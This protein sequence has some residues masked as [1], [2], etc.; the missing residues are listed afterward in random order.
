MSDTPYVKEKT[1]GEK[2][3]ICGSIDAVSVSRDELP[4]LIQELEEYTV[5]CDHCDGYCRSRIERETRICDDC[6][7]H[8][9]GENV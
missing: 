4:D 9:P 2:L 1:V 6:G 8:V 3:L 5:I 7:G